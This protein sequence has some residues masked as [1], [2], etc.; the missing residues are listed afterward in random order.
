MLTSNFPKEVSDT[1]RRVSNEIVRT[2][3]YMDFLR[4]RTF[5]QTL[6]CRKEAVLTRNLGPQNVM[7]LR[8]ASPAQP[9]SEPVD[10]RSTRPEEFRFPNGRTF[11]TASPLVKAAFQYLAEIW[12]QSVTFDDL[13]NTARSR[14][15]PVLIQ[16]G[17][18]YARQAQVLGADF[19][20]S[21][22]ANLVELHVHKANFVT[23]ASDHP[24]AD[25]LAREQAKTGGRVT[26][27]RH[28][29]TNLD[30]FNRH[31]LR[32]LDGSRDREAIVDGLVN[33]V[34]SGTLVVQ[35][36]GKQIK[37]GEPLRKILSEALDKN[38]PIMAKAALLVA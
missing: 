35:Q 20:T 16:D 25:A 31:V 11:T 29:A 13:L 10:L 19:L 12:P 4:N 9:V 34:T 27:R 22:T 1:L 33:L 6:L 2:E 24:M 17:E 37:E 28:E 21:F 18:T 15:T 23:H 8:I 36:E 5:R 3:Q 14:L 7:S 32:L 38:L 26:N 30:E